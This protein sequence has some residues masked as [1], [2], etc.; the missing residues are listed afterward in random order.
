MIPRVVVDS[1]CPR[2]RAYIMDAA[3]LG[4]DDEGK[5]VVF[6]PDNRELAIRLEAV[7]EADLHEEYSLDELVAVVTNI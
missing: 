6:H 7:L 5:I 2:D 4:I 3:R 1:I